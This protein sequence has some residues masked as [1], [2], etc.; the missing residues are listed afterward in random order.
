VLI[1]QSF[2]VDQFNLEITVL[3][4]DRFEI[5]HG[6]LVCHGISLAIFKLEHSIA[7]LK[8]PLR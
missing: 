8:R 6:K 1:E 4:W 5:C 7:N 2:P 3:I